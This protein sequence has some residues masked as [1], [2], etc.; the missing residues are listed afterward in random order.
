MLGATRTAEH[1]ASVFHPVS[2]HAAAAVI[3]NRGQ[4]VN[5]AFKGIEGMLMAVERHREG[6]VVIVAAGF[7]LRHGHRLLKRRVSKYESPKDAN[8]V[9]HGE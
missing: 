5:R 1:H 3:A 6:F 4:G 2:N 7:A 9:P 8:R